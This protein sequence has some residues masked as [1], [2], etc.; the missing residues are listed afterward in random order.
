M[1]N[2]GQYCSLIAF[3]IALF[4]NGVFVVAQAQKQDSFVPRDRSL[5]RAPTSSPVTR[6]PTTKAPTKPTVQIC[7]SRGL[8][9]CPTGKI[10]VD[11]D[12]KASCTIA[13]DCPGICVP[14]PAPTKAPTGSAVCKSA[15][16]E[17]VGKSGTDA[18]KAIQDE[19]LAPNCP[20]LQVFIVQDGSIVTTDYRLDRVRIYVNKKGIVSGIPIIG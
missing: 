20:K 16:P 14:A 17:L 8:P 13:S 18:A 19:P 12:P 4:P 7:G 1:K 15:W 6:K 5:L 11:K 3:L 10:C 9:P 2:L